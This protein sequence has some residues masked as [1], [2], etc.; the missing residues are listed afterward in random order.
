[1]EFEEDDR[2]MGTCSMKGAR[3]TVQTSDIVKDEGGGRGGR[4]I[5]LCSTPPQ[6]R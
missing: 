1:M 2:E 6:T 3:L 4:V 5:T